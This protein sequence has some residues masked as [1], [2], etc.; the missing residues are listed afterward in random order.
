MELYNECL[1]CVYNES[2][3]NKVDTC[4]ECKRNYMEE[5][6]RCITMLDKYETY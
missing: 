1:G 3:S 6:E 5:D 2:E 4:I